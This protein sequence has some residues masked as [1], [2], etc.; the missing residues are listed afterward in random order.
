MS[1]KP[2]KTETTVKTFDAEDNLLSETV[3]TVVRT[4]ATSDADRP[5]LYL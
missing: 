2:V 3:T 4:D 5:G 1:E